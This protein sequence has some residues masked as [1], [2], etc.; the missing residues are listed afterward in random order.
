[1]HMIARSLLASRANSKTKGSWT[2]LLTLKK[3]FQSINTY[4]QRYD[5]TCTITLIKEEKYI[6]SLLRIDWKMMSPFIQGWFVP[7]LVE[8]PIGSGEDLQILSICIFCYLVIFSDWERAWPLT[9]N[10]LSP[11]HL[12]VL[13]AKFGWNLS[14]SFKFCSYIFAA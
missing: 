8:W 2:K 6:I 12:R 7:S 9:C 11:L 4:M 1:M 10:N 13:C 3:H 5:Y 14:D